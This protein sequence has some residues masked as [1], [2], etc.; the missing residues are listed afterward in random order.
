MK[1]TN[2]KCSILYNRSW[3]VKP[4]REKKLSD[5]IINFIN[6]DRGVSDEV[7]QIAMVITSNIIKEISDAINQEDILPNQYFERKGDYLFSGY[8]IKINVQW[9]FYNVGDSSQITNEMRTSA[10][11]NIS[12]HEM[13]V[14]LLS[15]NMRYDISSFKETIQHETMH[16]F[17]N[18][19]RGYAPYKEQGRYDKAYNYL[20]QNAG[21]ST[22]NDVLDETSKTILKIRRYIAEIIYI[23]TAYEQRAFANGAY[24]YLMLHQKDAAF[25]FSTAIQGTK[26]FDWLKEI[27]DAIKF[28][29]EYN[30]EPELLESELEEYKIDRFELMSIAKGARKNLIRQ[31][32]RIISKAIDDTEKQYPSHSAI[33]PENAEEKSARLTKMWTMLNKKY[34]LN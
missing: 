14:T 32:G 8:G 18:Y 7:S 20:K 11:A 24:S 28:L 13:T 1:E 9:S 5:E 31:M 3:T 17:E 15:V 25:K 26:L 22:N 4:T 34:F 19:K 2:N 30:G 10:V 12:K 23:S 27:E 33:I 29:A 16:F 6:E 21:D